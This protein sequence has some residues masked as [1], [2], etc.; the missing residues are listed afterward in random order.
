MTGRSCQTCKHFEPS[1][2][3]RKGWC[4][5]PRLYAPRESHIVDAGSLDCSRGL[6]SAWEAA[7][8]ATAPA[9]RPPD[10]P[11]RRPLVFFPSSPQLALAGA[12]GPSG[13]GSFIA[14][15]SGGENSGGG[16]APGPGRPERPVNPVGQERIVSFQPEE[17]YWTDYLRIALPVIG[18]LILIALLWYWASALIGGPSGSEP[19]PAQTPFTE[20]APTAAAP[21]SPIPSPTPTAPAITPTPGVAPTA[22]PAVTNP[23]VEAAPTTATDGAT[24][25]QN[26]LPECQNR[27]TYEP[28]TTVVTSADVNFRTE[29]TSESAAIALLPA[30]TELQ[31]TGA[32]VDL[33]DC[34]WWPVTNPATGESGYVREDFLEAA[35]Q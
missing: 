3:W 19:T 22:A 13:A 24:S 14:R 32:F 20:V 2:I 16:D 12:G 18:L 25:G 35:G 30:G 31:T 9:V 26:T 34:D 11:Q 5:N 29:A 21:A 8:P 17:R 33:P 4:R 6:G 1:A 28:G 27:D 7:E 23:T 15:S 10:Q